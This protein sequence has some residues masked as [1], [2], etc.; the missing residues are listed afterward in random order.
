MDLI[1]KYPLEQFQKVVKVFHPDDR[2]R[3]L[4]HCEIGIT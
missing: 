1:G 4:V 2:L 3:D